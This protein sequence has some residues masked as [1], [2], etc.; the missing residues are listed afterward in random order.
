[1]LR[2]H[3]TR[4]DLVR[5]R[6]ADGPDPMWETVLS[7]QMLRARYSAAIFDG[8]RRRVR[9]ALYDRD[10]AAMVRRVLFPLTPDA[11]Y[12]PDFLTPAE[13]LLGLA[14]GVAA[15]RATPPQRL[16]REIR[17]L[18]I[19]HDA[20]PSWA[21]TLIA[22]EPGTLTELGEALTGYH[23]TA[24]GTHW[25]R[26]RTGAEIDVAR[27]SLQQ[28]AGGTARMLSGFGPMMRWRAPVLEVPYPVER[29][30]HLD[31]R[32]LVLI[33]SYF[34]WY[35]PVGLADPALPPTLVYP[36]RP[37]ADF[38]EHSPLEAAEHGLTRLLGP[39]RARV[40]ATV[41]AQGVT[42]SELARRNGISAGTASQH[43]T[44]LRE[45][46]LVNSDRRDNVVIHTVTPLGAALLGRRQ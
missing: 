2:I 15:I 10:Q 30:L 27:R 36:L 5:T 22:A 44:V 33:P 1:M 12:F 18:R 40:L 8:W 7:L 46:G 24:L 25:D 21:R 42:T 6:L 32:G 43:A 3:F 31:G 37:A 34:C 38:L 4:T 17:R 26:M 20:P 41:G 29:D 39:T 9:A 28:R 35:H 45:S 19:P 13:G 23:R 14:D 16:R 11:S